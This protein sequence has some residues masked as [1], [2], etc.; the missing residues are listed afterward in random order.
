MVAREFL[1]G[2]GYNV[3][4]AG[5]AVG[6]NDAAYFTRVFLDLEGSSPKHFLVKQWLSFAPLREAIVLKVLTPATL[7][8]PSAQR[9]DDVQQGRSGCAA[10]VT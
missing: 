1:S 2:S 10:S 8:T 6:F 9:E 5:Y 3:T 4:E 7:K